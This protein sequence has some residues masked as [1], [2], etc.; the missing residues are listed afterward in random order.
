M[1]A[2]SVEEDVLGEPTTIQVW[3]DGRMVFLELTD[4]R[5]IGFPA[6]RFRLLKQATDE[7]SEPRDEVGDGNRRESMLASSIDAAMEQ[8]VCE[9]IEDEV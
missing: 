4:G 6:N 5:I 7:Q 8:A 1:R 2:I 3:V 9:I